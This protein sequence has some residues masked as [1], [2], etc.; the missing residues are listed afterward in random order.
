MP[1]VKNCLESIDD[2]ER[3]AKNIV[4]LVKSGSFGLSSV[5][6]VLDILKNMTDLAKEFGAMWPE[7]KDIN[8][9]EAGQL[10]S[11]LWTMG[12][13]IYEQIT[14]VSIASA[15][16]AATGTLP[17]AAAH[18][19]AKPAASKDKPKKGDATS[20]AAGQ[21]LAGQPAAGQPAAGQQAPAQQQAAGEPAAGQSSAS[22]IIGKKS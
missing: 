17:P 22:Q 2:A 16:A 8:A 9:D 19:E 1:D 18:A 11:R 10:G 7:I 20:P 12:S 14:G 15:A 6:H 3:I 5:P 4:T 13:H 21:P